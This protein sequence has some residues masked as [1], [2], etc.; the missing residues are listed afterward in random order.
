MCVICRD[1][2]DYS[3][4]KLDCSGCTTLT[5]IPNINGLKIL[6]CSDCPK[7]VKIPNMGGLKRLKCNNCP[8]LT[9]IPQILEL[10]SLFSS[11][12]TELTPWLLRRQKFQIF[13]NYVYFIVLIVP[14]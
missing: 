3:K 4:T 11:N 9:E 5:E 6:C 10:E 12:C 1:E 13:Q 8:K 14:N 2:L 7:L